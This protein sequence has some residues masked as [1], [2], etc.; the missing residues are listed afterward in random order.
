[1]TMHALTH[2]ITPESL[3]ELAIAILRT[4]I[5]VEQP[6]LRLPALLAGQVQR[7]DDQDND[8]ARLPAHTAY[9]HAV[10]NPPPIRSGACGG[11]S[12]RNAKKTRV[13]F[14]ALAWDRTVRRERFPW[15]L[16]QAP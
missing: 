13:T 9:K 2:A 1:M 7:L 8:E 11:L 10:R 16:I 6:R 12:G 5:L 3:G 15:L 4:L 14:V